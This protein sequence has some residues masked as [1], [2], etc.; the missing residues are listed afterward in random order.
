MSAP[1]TQQGKGRQPQVEEGSPGSASKP[2]FYGPTH[3]RKRSRQDD[4]NHED[5]DE[6]PL[7]PQRMNQLP[8]RRTGNGPEFGAEI[9]QGTDTA[10]RFEQFLLAPGEPKVEMEIDTREFPPSIS[11]PASD[12][13]QAP[14]IQSFSP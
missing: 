2:K 12:Q 7:S 11:V 3:E 6:K 8:W 1:S 4:P 13:T 9:V 10:D 5:D 14:P